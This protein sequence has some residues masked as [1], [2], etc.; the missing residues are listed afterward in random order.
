[1]EGGPAR[2]LRDACRGWGLGADPGGRRRLAGQPA[3]LARSNT[4]VR[5]A[6]HKGD[7]RRHD[8]AVVLPDDA[9][10]AAFLVLDHN[11]PLKH[12]AHADLLA[13]DH[14]VEA[15]ADFVIEGW[16]DAC[17]RNEINDLAHIVASLGLGRRL[18]AAEIKKER[19]TMFGGS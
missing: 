2:G 14:G 1:L 5:V 10:L 11:R 13:I 6:W 16:N 19:R 3:P 8:H 7:R 15:A 12:G 18:Q 17:Q 9:S 4:V